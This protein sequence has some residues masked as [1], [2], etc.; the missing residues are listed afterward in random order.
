MPVDC[1]VFSHSLKARTA[2]PNNLTSIEIHTRLSQDSPFR[3]VAVP[4]APAEL[5]A[6]TISPPGRF[7]YSIKFSRPIWAIETLTRTSP[8]VDPKRDARQTHC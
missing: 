8:Q 4:E 6:L 7:R 1:F 3:Q 5:C 2:A